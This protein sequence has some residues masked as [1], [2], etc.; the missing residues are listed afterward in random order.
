MDRLDLTNASKLQ[1]R[2]NEIDS[3]HFYS[4]LTYYSWSFYGLNISYQFHEKGISFFGEINLEKNL[5]HEVLQDK[6]CPTQKVIFAPITK[7]NQPDDFLE[8]IKGQIE[9]LDK[10]QAIYIDDLTG[11]ELEWVKSKYDVEIIHESSTNFF[12]ETKKMMTLAG[13]SLQKKRNHLNFFIKQYEKDAKIKINQEVD[14]NQLEKFYLT[15]INDCEDPSAYQSELALFRAIK[16][17]IQDGSLKLTALYYLD[18][19]IGFCVSY[20]LNNRCEIFIEHCDET[21]RGSYQYLL[22]NSLRIHHSNDALTDRQ[23]D[24]GSASISY[25]KLSYKPEFIIKRYLVKVIC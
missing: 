24:M 12:Y 5:L 8:L 14:L 1:E 25:S 2:I 4:A 23:D 19:I 18:Q 15:W 3:S 16:P 11:I 13:K 20:S 9:Q 17:L 22:S 21:Y 7:P 6:Y 10:S